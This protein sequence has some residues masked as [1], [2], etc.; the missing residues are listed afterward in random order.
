MLK[1]LWALALLVESADKIMGATCKLNFTI[2]RRMAL[3]I[4]PLIPFDSL[5]WE[6]PTTPSR[7]VKMLARSD[8]LAREPRCI[9]ML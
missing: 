8:C 3:L 1:L 4:E 7:P 2:I 5:L 6:S 9:H